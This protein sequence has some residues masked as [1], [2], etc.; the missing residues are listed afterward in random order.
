MRP[1][2]LPNSLDTVN[3]RN[4]CG[5][6]PS[7]TWKFSTQDYTP[8]AC[9]GACLRLSIFIFTPRPKDGSDLPDTCDPP[10]I[11]LKDAKRAVRIEQD[12]LP[13]LRSPEENRTPMTEPR[14]D[15]QPASQ[16]QMPEQDNSLVAEVESAAADAEPMG[17]IA[18]AVPGSD[19]I[20]ADALNSGK[21][22]GAEAAEIR[23]QPHTTAGTEA[24]LEKEEGQIA[25]HSTPP[26]SR[27]A[28]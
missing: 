26:A 24:R 8:P 2:P 13:H 17:S 22:P 25:N 12:A 23:N 4:I 20:A 7:A 21:Q 11:P 3:A 9:R 1:P 27:R 16:K 6:P 18:A 14:K 15:P 28:S 10:F 19:K 5:L